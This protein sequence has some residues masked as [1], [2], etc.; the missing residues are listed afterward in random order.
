MYVCMCVYEGRTMMVPPVWVRSGFSTLRCT[1]KL[2]RNM[3]GGISVMV[4]TTKDHCKQI[5]NTHFHDGKKEVW[6]I[7]LSEV[8]QEHIVNDNKGGTELHQ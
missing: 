8:Y 2:G 3:R 5:K 6:M 7:F 4:A 1:R